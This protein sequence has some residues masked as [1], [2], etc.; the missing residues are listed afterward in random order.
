MT[1]IMEYN[2]ELN[3][4]FMDNNYRTMINSDESIVNGMIKINKEKNK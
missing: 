4:K 1:E 3:Y 2:S